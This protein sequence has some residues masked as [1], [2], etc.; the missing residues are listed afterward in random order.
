M[1]NLL[2]LECHELD[3]GTV[4]IQF[5]TDELTNAGF[6]KLREWFREIVHWMNDE[7]IIYSFSTRHV[8]GCILA[9]TDAMLL[10]LRFG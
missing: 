8:Y 9:P 6:E 1:M 10:K 5:F 4:E 3:N 7:G 2:D